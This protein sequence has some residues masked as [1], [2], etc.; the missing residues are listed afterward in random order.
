MPESGF[1][2]CRF[3]K[4]FKEKAG[5]RSGKERK[6]GSEAGSPRTGLGSDSTT[7]RLSDPAR[8]CSLCLENKDNPT[9]SQGDCPKPLW[10][11]TLVLAQQ[12]GASE[13]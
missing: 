1:H 11:G 4:H 10:V 6:N 9:S 7:C 3:Y 2:P 5:W 8:R 12:V 13:R